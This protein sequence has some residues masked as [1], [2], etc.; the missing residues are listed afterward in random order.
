ML[1]SFAGLRSLILVFFVTVG[2]ALNLGCV[3]ERVSRR[4]Q[5]AHPE[6]RGHGVAEREGGVSQ[7]VV[8]VMTPMSF[9]AI[10]KKIESEKRSSKMN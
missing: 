5:E 8:V 4:G 2:Q 10:S 6:D 7:V 9:F 3:P 1:L